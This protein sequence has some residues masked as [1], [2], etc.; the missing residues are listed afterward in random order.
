[1][2]QLLGECDAQGRDVFLFTNTEKNA[3]IYDHFGFDTIKKHTVEELN[4]TTWFM[5]HRAK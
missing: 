3:S 4:S 1:M 2:R 5:L